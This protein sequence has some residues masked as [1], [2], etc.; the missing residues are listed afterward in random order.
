VLC[1]FVQLQA[2]DI[3]ITLLSWRQKLAR[4]QVRAA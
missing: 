1:R 3:I 2:A 4:T